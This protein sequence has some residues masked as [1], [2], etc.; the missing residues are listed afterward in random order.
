M[1]ND[2]KVVATKVATLPAGVRVRPPPFP[3]PP[4]SAPPSD[5]PC[6]HPP[7]FPAHPPTN[8]QVS[9]RIGEL[10]GELYAAGT[11]AKNFDKVVKDLDA[12]ST[13]IKGSG[14]VVERFFSSANYSP[15]ECAKVVELLLTQK[16]PLASF[17]DIKDVDVREVLVDNEGNLEAWRGARKAVAALALCEPV[18]AA[19]DSC[20]RDGHLERVKKLAAYAAELASVSSK[21]LSAVVTSAVPLTKA[22]QEAVAKAIPSYVGGFPAG[23]SVVP[24]FSV[25]AA[26]VGGLTV[27]IKNQSVDLS[28]NSRLVDVVAQA[29][30]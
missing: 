9:G 8:L 29:A 4:P 22:Q 6:P 30:P 20:A 17:K 10:L 2:A 3:P 24:V 12:F 28:A 21:T 16:E 13:V 15:E 26:I 23:T 18:K 11:A 27:T 7:F 25:D 14:L 19:L 1:E 5:P